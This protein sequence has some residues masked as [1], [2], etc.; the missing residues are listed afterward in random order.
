[1][2]LSGTSGASCGTVISEGEVSSKRT[3]AVSQ[4]ESGKEFKDQ[5]LRGVVEC[6]RPGCFQRGKQ[7]CARC[8]SVGYCSKS[9][10]KAHWDQHKPLCSEGKRQQRTVESS[11]TYRALQ[12]Q[13]E[14]ALQWARQP[15][16]LDEAFQN[17][18]AIRDGTARAKALDVA[19]ARGSEVRQARLEYNASVERVFLDQ[20]DGER[21]LA[22]D[23]SALR[24]GPE[25][26]AMV[27]LYRT[28]QEKHGPSAH[29]DPPD[30]T[31]MRSMM[32]M[33]Y[34]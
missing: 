19:T 9:C 23:T 27:A 14:R 18:C 17:M 15:T 20:S 34:R 31:K 3:V 6:G 13:T 10:Q 32:R 25:H 11:D 16:T 21:K 12:Q 2:S 7:A 29:P 22:L 33:L 8:H 30:L 24:P 1:M 28:Y 5:L 4:S 26:E